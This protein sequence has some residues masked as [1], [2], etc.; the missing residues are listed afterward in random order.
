MTVSFPKTV[1]MG[2]ILNLGTRISKINLVR[3]VLVAAIT[4]L[5]VIGINHVNAATLLPNGEQQF[6]D[7][8]GLPLAGGTVQFF[9]PGTLS[10]KDTYQNSGQTVLNSNP[11]VLDGSGRAIIYG[12]GSYRQI[13]RDFQGN[14]LWDQLTADTSSAGAINAGGISGGTANAQTVVAG[15]FTSQSGQS[16]QFFA[17]FTNTASMTLIPSSAGGIAVLKDTSSGPVA[18]TGGEVVVGNSY[19]VVYDS[20]L[21]AFHLVAYPLNSITISGNLTVGG[22]ATIT[23]TLMASGG[24]V[25][26]P[27]EIRTFAMNACPPTWLETNGAAVSRTTDAALFTAIGTT[28]G[29]GDGSTTFNIPDFRG[30]FLRDWADTGSVDP[31]RAFASTQ[32]DAMQTHEFSYNGPTTTGS[33]GSGGAA[34]FDF[35]ISTQSTFSNTGRTAAETRPVNIAVLYCIKT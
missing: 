1:P 30:Y 23:G 28:W 19:I 17:G 34:G 5:S 9:V 22:N 35:G 4:I 12:S 31:G 10:V 32:Q 20:T 16:I 2:M 24:L 3:I 13:V 29:T 6:L 14:L 25:L 21:G 11:V 27:G 7:N 18:L 26:I 15:S 8:N 33:G